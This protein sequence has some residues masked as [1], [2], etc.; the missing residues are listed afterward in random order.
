MCYLRNS[1]KKKR[2]EPAQGIVNGRMWVK[3]RLSIQTR[4]NKSH[5]KT[6]VKACVLLIIKGNRWMK[7]AAQVRI[8]S[9][10]PQYISNTGWGPWVQQSLYAWN[11]E[12]QSTQCDY[13]NWHIIAV[14]RRDKKCIKIIPWNLKMCLLK[15]LYVIFD[16]DKVYIP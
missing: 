16:C 15:V 12:Q 13:F 6:V 1:K 2:W 10:W 8:Y 14:E 7:T 5:L 4:I 9:L 3:T 11:M